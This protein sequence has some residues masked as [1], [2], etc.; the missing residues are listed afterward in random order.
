MSSAPTSTP[1]D[2]ND[3]LRAM[4]AAAEAGGVD[5][6]SSDP[7]QR[8]R[9]AQAGLDALSETVRRVEAAQSKEEARNL[10]ADLLG[11]A[12]AIEAIGIAWL[13]NWSTVEALLMRLPAGSVSTL[14][15]AVKEAADKIQESPPPKKAN[16]PYNLGRKDL[17]KFTVPEGWR[18]DGDG[19]HQEIVSKDGVSLRRVSAVP[20]LLTAVFEHLYVHEESVQIEWRTDG[21]WHKRVVSRLEVAD[22]HRLVGLAKGGIG[23]TSNN[24]RDLTAWF[25]DWEAE[26]D[27]PRSYVTD[28]MGW[29]VDSDQH[30]LGFLS[31]IRF[32][33]VKGCDKAVALEDDEGKAQ[34]ANAYA[35]AGTME[36]WKDAVLSVLEYPSAMLAIYASLAAPFLQLLPRAPNAILDWCGSTSHGKTTCLSLAASCWGRPEKGDHIVHSWDNSPTYLER[37]AALTHHLPLIVDDTKD[38]RDPAFIERVIYQFSGRSGRGRGS[39]DGIRATVETRGVLLSSGE[40]P[41][42]AFGSAAGSRARTLVLR[43]RP[44]GDGNQRELVDGLL[45]QLATHHGHA[46]PAVVSWLAEHPEEWDRLHAWWSDRVTEYGKAA[47]GI[48]V[49]GRFGGL[50]ALIELGAYALHVFLGVE[51]PSIDPFAFAWEAARISAEDADRPTEALQSVWAWAVSNQADFWE[52]H[53]MLPDKTPRRPAKGWAGKWSAAGFWDEICWQ[54]EALLRVLVWQGYKNPEEVLSAWQERGW[55]KMDGKNRAAH[56]RIENGARMRMICIGRPTIEA[57]VGDLT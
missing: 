56:R 57:V 46:G 29:Q 4:F 31:G 37:I 5:G 30:V 44:F 55:I 43:G 47:G 20:S 14:R 45:G 28:R 49:L 42:T 17:A 7:T 52:R 27:L 10:V 6:A 1:G 48:A 21:I 39:L 38:T 34:L 22:A 9:Q 3:V 25:S 54:P 36:G 32:L 24:A 26:N 12:A 15:R 53:T 33:P 11:N 18:L 13:Q 2:L 40:Q 23:A 35:P 51:R 8:A 16:R 41:L 50:V 19:I